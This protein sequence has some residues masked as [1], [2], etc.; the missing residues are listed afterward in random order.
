[1]QVLAALQELRGVGRSDE[2]NNFKCNSFWKTQRRNCSYSLYG[3]AR[4]A[5]ASCKARQSVCVYRA[6]P[7]IGW[8]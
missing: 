3:W 5:V 2:S 4:C 1:M 6:P 7:T 8:C